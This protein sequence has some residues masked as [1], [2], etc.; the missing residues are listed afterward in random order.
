MSQ[1]GL[2]PRVTAAAEQA[3]AT[4]KYVTPL[5]VC[6]A[7]GWLSSSHVDRWRQGQVA[8]L[9]EALPVDA[10][11]LADMLGCVE[12]WAV[13]KGL[14]RGAASYIAATRDRR[15]L[16]FTADGAG[17]TERAWRVQWTSSE[18][19]GKQA[20]RIT[21]KQSAAPDLVVVQPVKDF[22]C[23][24]CGVV[25]GDMLI[26]DTKGPLCLTCADMDHL[27]FLPSGNAALTRRSK[28]ASGLSAVVVRWS[29]SRKRYERQGLLVEETALEQ[30]EQECLA[31]EDVR[32]R[33]RE[34]DA[35]RRAEE[36]VAFQAR[37]AAG[38][39]RI[40]PGCPQDRAEAIAAHAAVRGS[41]RVGR[42][43]AARAL[44]ARAITL[45]VVAS[46]RHQDTDYDSLLM[47]GVAR[48]D[49]RERIASAI[50]RVLTAWS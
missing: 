25:A 31:D 3:L 18:L 17:D 10:A 39:A 36:D 33:R 20:E 32:A 40:Y 38:I 43:A 19:T 6:V 8:S 27:V 47:S 49:A 4:R 13:G 50:D 11:K 37:F 24:E 45:A 1:R 21:R 16:R 44:D 46:V 22:S 12:N 48:D 28:K 41:G 15:E 34:R 29:K 5:D 30:A 23:A 42:S 35:G 9:E 14:N 2:A 7:I 26:M